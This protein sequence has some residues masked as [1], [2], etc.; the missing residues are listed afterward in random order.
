MVGA[1]RRSDGGAGSAAGPP[2]EPES[3][4]TRRNIST[5]TPE[6]GKSDHV[7]SADT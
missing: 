1:C 4:T 6:S 7:E 2:A 5:K 3:A